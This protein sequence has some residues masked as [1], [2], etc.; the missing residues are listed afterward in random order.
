MTIEEAIE[1]INNTNFYSCFTNEKQDKAFEMALFSLSTYAG[2]KEDLQQ[3]ESLDDPVAV[4]ISALYRGVITEI[5][6]IG[7]E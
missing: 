3:L 4:Q 7:G 2:I 1:I 5:E 6:K